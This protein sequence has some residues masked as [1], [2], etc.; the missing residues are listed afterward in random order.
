MRYQKQVR[1]HMAQSFMSVAFEGRILT[2]MEG[3]GISHDASRPLHLNSTRF[4]HGIA[5]LSISDVPA[6]VIGWLG[7]HPYAD[8]RQ[9]RPM[10]HEGGSHKRVPNI[11]FHRG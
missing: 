11:C 6:I 2:I 3:N 7:R 8:P 1:L 4:N 10:R 9:E 5:K